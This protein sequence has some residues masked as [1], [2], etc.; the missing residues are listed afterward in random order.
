MLRNVLAGER[1]EDKALEEDAKKGVFRPR[2]PVQFNECAGGAMSFIFPL[3][4]FSS[5]H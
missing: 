1:T 3:L 4:D 5:L 2:K